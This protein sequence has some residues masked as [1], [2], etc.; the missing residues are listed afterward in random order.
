MPNCC[1]FSSIAAVHAT[2]SSH[3][4]AVSPVHATVS[5][6]RRTFPPIYT[7]AA[8]SVDL[9]NLPLHAPLPTH[10]TYVRVRGGEHGFEGLNGRLEVHVGGEV[11]LEGARAIEDDA[12]GSEKL[13]RRVSKEL[14][15]I[16]QVAEDQLL[17][18][19]AET[20]VLVIDLD[21]R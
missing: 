18:R 11:G 3:R 13:W 1:T 9:D 2:V 15:S 5:F 8:G 21:P 20:Y 16:G 17:A 6:I 14:M 19:C 12:A 7:R 4:C 10:H